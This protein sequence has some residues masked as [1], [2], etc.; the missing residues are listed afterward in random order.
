MPYS[1]QIGHSYTRRDVYRVIGIPEDTHGGNWDTGYA[2]HGNDWFIFC[3]VGT[4]GRTGHDYANKWVGDRLEWY[5]KT[6]SQLHH[7]SIQS[8]LSLDSDT[9][10]FWRENNQQPFIFAGIG[11]AEEVEDITPVKIIWTFAT[12]IFPDEI[13]ASAILREGAVCKVSVNAYER[14]PVVRQQCIK[15]YGTSCY[16]C[17]FNFGK[18]FGKLGEGFI[19]VH[20]L[21]PLSEI[22]EEYEVNPVEDLRPVCPNCHAMIHRRSPPLSIEEVKVLIT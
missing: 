17:G 14:N 6:N 20:H 10:I 3:N 11:N 7:P 15:H 13:P 18:I 2:R 21:R 9:Y 1:F 5:G 22:R 19:H 4:S 16:I 12:A 8:M